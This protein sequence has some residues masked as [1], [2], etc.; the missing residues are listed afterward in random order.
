MGKD[1]KKMS[2]KEKGMAMLN[3]A[4]A[5]W[6][7][8]GEVD[9][10]DIAGDSKVLKKSLGKMQDYAEKKGLMNEPEKVTGKKCYNHK[11]V[12][13]TIKC[14]NCSKPICPECIQ[15]PLVGQKLYGKPKE[16]AKVPHQVCPKCV[17]A[18]LKEWGPKSKRAIKGYMRTH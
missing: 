5:K 17:D 2:R 9:M 1:K 3:A 12:E 6:Q 16:L 13:A 15:R 10:T 4:A 8:T 18:V 11:K 7:E 14:Q